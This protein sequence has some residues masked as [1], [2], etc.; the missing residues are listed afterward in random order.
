MT[1]QY[2][3]ISLIESTRESPSIKR[4]R[5]ADDTNKSKI[6][7]SSNYRGISITTESDTRTKLSRTIE[8]LDLSVRNKSDEEL[9]AISIDKDFK[10]LSS[11]LKEKLVKIIH[12]RVE[13]N[14]VSELAK[15]NSDNIPE[16][17]KLYTDFG[18]QPCDICFEEPSIYAV[19]D[20]G[21]A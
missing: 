14:I 16:S 21:H 15:M 13:N 2:N 4:A 8:S 20:C 17:F 1:N 19:F 6:T 3:T 12:K 11:E 9:L 10:D 7:I 18:L 5:T